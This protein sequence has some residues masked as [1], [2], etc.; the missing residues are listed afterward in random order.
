MRRH[1]YF[2]GKPLPLSSAG[3]T[4]LELIIMVAMMGIL[5]AIAA[6][7]WSSFV[8]RQQL[9]SAQNQVYRAMQDAKNNATRDKIT[10]QVSFRQIRLNEKDV[11]QWSIHPAES[12]KF[13]PFSVINNNALWHNLDPNVLI[14]TI[15][16]NKGKYETSLTKQTTAGPWRVQYNYYGCPVSQVNDEC[17][18]TSL[19][20]LGRI[21]LR[22]KSGS[23]LRRC[24]ITSTLLG[25][26]RAG[27]DYP[28]ADS[29]GKYC[30]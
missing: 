21:T 28:K 15:K 30:H 22:S 6:P 14:D 3:Y 8:E 24:M 23:K 17:G 7:A 29:T 5:S 16:N 12:G 9:N 13:I 10:W 19:T 11:V 2:I 1:R 18:Q 20:A 27:R 26:M 4:L 25:A